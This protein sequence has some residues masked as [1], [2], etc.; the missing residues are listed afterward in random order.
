MGKELRLIGYPIQHSLSPWIHGEFFGRAGIK[1]NYRLHEIPLSD[2]LEEGVRALKEVGVDGFNVTVPYKQEII[3]FLDG[4]DKTAERMG[5][6]NTVA[7]ENGK[8]IGY[9]TDGTG[10]LRSLEHSYPAV[11]KGDV[12]TLIL[13]AGGAARAIYFALAD[14]GFKA[15]DIANRTK[16]SAQQIVSH[17]AT[18][19][20][21]RV[22]SLTE[23][24]V[25]IHNY[26]LVIQTSSVGMKPNPERAIVS[27]TGMRPAAIA[28]DIVYQPIMTKFLKDAGEAGALLHMGHTMLIY[29]AQAAFEIW[30]GRKVS[31]EDMDRQLQ[32]KLEGR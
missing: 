1:G 29:Q 21:S 30:T 2:N 25:G 9:N 15:V 19:A 4:L 14:A 18:Q 3:P 5:A 17:G 6:V 12:K 26:G 24:E 31:A 32:A 27:A 13:G 11:T 28:S 16:E 22:L 7:V 10:Y 23:A 8:W 20:E